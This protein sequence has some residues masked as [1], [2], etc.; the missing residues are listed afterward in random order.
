MLKTL[1]AARVLFVAVFA[2][3][4]GSCDSGPDEQ[5]PEGEA[6]WVQLYPER[7]WQ[8]VDT[9][10]VLKVSESTYRVWTR[11]KSTD[12]SYTLFRWEVNCSARSFRGLEYRAWEGTPDGHI[13]ADTS[14]YRR[15]FGELFADSVWKEPEPEFWPESVVDGICAYL[16]DKRRG[17]RE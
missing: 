1:V 16:N 12:S 14:V 5:L 17:S 15:V 6:R 10:S 13:T 7:D 3:I 4:V 11:D 9:R 2:A 8:T